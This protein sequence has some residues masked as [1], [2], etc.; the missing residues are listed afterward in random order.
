MSATIVDVAAP[1]RLAREQLLR[2]PFEELVRQAL[3]A[4]PHHHEFAGVGVPGAEVEIRE[5]ALPPPV[6]PFGAEDDEVV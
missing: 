1:R 4:L 2:L 5:P 3:E 6:A